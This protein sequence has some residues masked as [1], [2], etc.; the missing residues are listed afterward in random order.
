MAE[1]PA[2]NANGVLTLSIKSNGSPVECQVFRAQVRRTI[3]VVP[4]A[5]LVLDDG[6][7]PRGE[8]D[9]ADSDSFAPGAKITISAGYDSHTETIFEGIVTRLGVR[10]DGDNVSRLH[11]SCQDAA[12]K[13]TIGRKNAN[14]IDMTD[15][16]IIRKIVGS[17]SGVSLS[18]VDSTSVTYG[19]LVQYY[20]T[21]WDFVLARAEANGLL[22]IVEDGAIS[23]KAPDTSSAAALQVAWGNDLFDF[24][25]EV[26]A[27]RQYSEVETVAWDPA[28][29]AIVSS[30]A[31]PKT[32]NEQGNLSS[33][34]L[35]QVAGPQTYGLQSMTALAPEALRAW[36]QAQQVKSGLARIQGQMSFPGS[37]LAKVGTLIELS[38]LGHRYNGSVF[39]GSVEHEL[40]DGI[41]RTTVGFGLPDAWFVERR[42]I[43]APPAAGWLP[44]AEGL[45]IGVVTKL[46]NDP[47]GES[48]VQVNL[49]VLQ[50]ENQ[51]VWARLM[52]Y[53]A[54]SSFG[55]F[56][57]PEIG[58]EVVVG[59][60]NNDPSSPVVLG[61]LY[62]SSRAP[63]YA[64][65]DA[66]NTKALVSRKKAKI[67]IDEEK[68][69]ITITTPA[70]NKVVISD[71][72]KS[73]LLSDQNGNTA[74]LSPSGIALDSPFD[75][76]LTAKGNISATATGSI[77]LTATAD[78]SAKGLNVAAEA[79][80]AISAKGAASAE[81]SATGQTVVR[82]AMV[83]IN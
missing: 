40:A 16:Q 55:A 74:K 42:D 82:G 4:T 35:A 21:D 18:G 13:L 54:S 52:Q 28:S 61:S 69:V 41:W 20:C 31:K 71:D 34:T 9:L 53:H 46:E 38:G 23:V 76:T 75:I 62:S 44:G 63:P 5:T 50:A 83:M 12:V 64:M 10:A 45:Q 80:I 58:D 37:A 3:G 70:N 43:V 22:V 66:N 60:F 47:K 59:Y 25:A 15:D 30:N 19:E 67:E 79:Q 57:L 2:N 78:L 68:V 39:V 49:P 27:R 14:Y 77:S 24:E 17:H 29:Q 6:D 7:M 73:I 36:A 56:Y 65:K 33:E 8:W 51:A 81:L 26:D 11:V 72:D 1:S 32:L 48:R